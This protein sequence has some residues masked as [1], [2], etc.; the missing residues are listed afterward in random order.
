MI[1]DSEAGRAATQIYRTLDALLDPPGD[2]DDG[3]AQ[4]AAIANAQRR[5]E[6]VTSALRGLDDLVDETGEGDR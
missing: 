3:D 6:N 5:C 2:R 1:R 4:D